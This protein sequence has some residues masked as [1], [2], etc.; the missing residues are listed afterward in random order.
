M[1]SFV[2]DYFREVISRLDAARIRQ[3]A[4]MEKCVEA[5]VTASQDDGRIYFF[6]TGHSHMLGVETHYRAGGLAATVP[7]LA[8]SIMVHEGTVAGTVHERM[9]GFARPILERYAIS[10]GDVLFV[11]SNSGVNAAPLEAAEIGRERGATVVA[12]TSVEYSKMVA[13]GRPRLAEMAHIVLDNEAPPGDAVLTV[14][15]SAQRVGPVSTIVGVALVNAILAEA[16]RRLAETS[17]APIYVSANMPG[18]D[19]INRQLVH[20]YRPRNPH[21]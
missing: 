18:A 9:P 21:L 2:D 5:I 7:V 17:G 15:G 6:G 13:N 11:T 19:E 4:A 16:S 1:T 8:G 20:R 10:R 14:S 12:I 3:A